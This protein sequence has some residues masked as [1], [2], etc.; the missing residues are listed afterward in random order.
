MNAMMKAKVEGLLKQYRQSWE[1]RST[2]YEGRVYIVKGIHV[3]SLMM[4]RVEGD[5]D[6]SEEAEFKTLFL[7]LALHMVL[8]PTQSPRLSSNLIPALT[9]AMSCKEYD[10]CSLVLS[11]LVGSLSSFAKRF[12]ANGSTGGCGGCLMFLVVSS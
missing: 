12:Y 8:C 7:I 3:N 11:K 1:T 6:E 5:R 4:E 9:C 10:W 2:K